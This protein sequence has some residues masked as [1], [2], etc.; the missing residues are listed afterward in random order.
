VGTLF[1]VG[2]ATLGRFRRS[3]SGSFAFLCWAVAPLPEF[4]QAQ[5]GALVL[6]QQHSKL[7]SSSVDV[8]P[9]TAAPL[10]KTET[11]SGQDWTM[12]WLMS[13]AYGIAVLI[14]TAFVFVIIW[15]VEKLAIKQGRRDHA[16]T[17]RLTRWLRF[18]S[19]AD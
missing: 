8:G 5:F 16:R 7:I 12:I 6:G 11:I 2:L 4:R 13:L 15:S 1:C 9:N 19:N 14:A 3:A 10:L 18:K 17:Y